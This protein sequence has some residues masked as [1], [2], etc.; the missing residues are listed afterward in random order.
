[1][2]TTRRGFL[3]SVAIVALTLSVLVAPATAPGAS[4]AEAGSAVSTP[5]KFAALS[6][7]EFDPG[8]IISDQLFYDGSAMSAAQIQS[9]L[10]GKIGSCLTTRCLNVAVLPVTGRAAS[11]SADTGALVCEAIAGG[12]MLASE[13]IYR[14]QVACGI[15]AKVILVTLQK[16]QGL[17]TSRAPSDWALRAAMGMGCP[18]TAPCSDAFSGL[19]TQIMAGTRQL[20]VYKVGRF[21]RQPGVQ[22]VQY[23]PNASCSGTTVNVRNY[24]T[25]ALYNY[26]PYQPN[27]ASLANLGGTGDS[28]S[29]YGNRNFWRY[30]STWFGSVD[31]AQFL[32]STVDTDY[33]I[34]RDASDELWA[35]PTTPGG[36]WGLRTSLGAGWGGVTDVIG[37]G[38]ID[39]NG[40]RDIIA[41]DT[42]GKTW[43]YPGGAVLEYPTRRQLAVD[44]PATSRL[45]YGGYVD[46][47]LDPD[48]LTIDAAG[49]LWMWPG[50]GLGGFGT[51][52]KVGSGFADYA[53]VAGVGD[54][55]GDRCAD[56]LAITSA[57]GLELR[58]GTCAG[59]FKPAIRI[60]VG[61]TGFTG[62]YTAG[63]FTGDGRV[64]LWAK[65]AGGTLRLFRGTGAGSISGTTISDAGWGT[66]QN[67]A[68]AGMRP[69][70]PPLVT[71]V[72]STDDMFAG[73]LITRDANNALWA[74]ASN[75]V[76]SWR[77]PRVS[78]GV[79]WAG[80][81]DVI[82]VGDLD[83]NGYRDVIARDNVGKSWFYPGDGR[84][85]YPTRRQITADWGSA[86]HL[87]YGGYFDA[88]DDPD[89]LTV[90]S[91]GKL[92]FWPGDGTGVF[93]AKVEV[94]DGFA[95]VVAIAG[96]G[97]FDGDRCGDLASLTTTGLL[98]LHSGDCAGG[99][100]AAR[101]I[102]SGLAGSKGVYAMGD[103]T[104]DRIADLWVMNA[105]GAIRLFRGTG[106][107]AV[108]ATSTFDHGWG[109]FQNI[110]G[111]GA[112][113]G[114]A[115]PAMTTGPEP[116]PTP[117]PTVTP[118]PTP[119]ATPTPTPTPT[120]PPTTVRQAGV[121]DVNS[122]GRRDILG[123]GAD[124][125]LRAY[126]GD[127]A[128]GIG[129]D[130]VIDATWGTSGVLHFPMGD[131]NGDG[132]SDI[133]MITTSGDFMLAKGDGSG[134]AKPVRLATQWGD[135]DVI[136]G[137]IDWDGDGKSDIVGR[138]RTGD[139][140]LYRGDGAGGWASLSGIRLATGWNGYRPIAVGDF[141]GV[142]G[143]DMLALQS[144]GDLWLYRG[145]GAGGW[146][147]LNGTR[148]G[149]GFTQ[150]SDVFSPGDFNGVP[151]NDLLVRAPDGRLYL[152]P[153]TGT[154]E[155]GTRVQI[156]SGWQTFR[157]IL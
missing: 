137:A 84:L 39:G 82:G 45:L 108:A 148:I 54:F 59:G 118:T 105:E 129:G 64:D 32:I 68:G 17:V 139:L 134:F 27:A 33:L 66:M 124:G 91:A 29:S 35:Y 106:G 104:A 69:A 14:T 131:W 99:I 100:K 3:A 76:G 7:S 143:D 1:M 28:C 89:M 43:F 86:R 18:D 127:G 103:F 93:G 102:G 24:A 154:G 34:T 145:N 147:S 88:G 40:Y 101:Q 73:Y 140:W 114:S 31:G 112:R 57:G 151:G 56:L 83:G 42:A 61:F 122:D 80:V 125:K 46:V 92:W 113:P 110:S 126:Y 49:D 10:D 72:S 81:K 9:F 109:G 51:A 52:V 50:D 111:S 97:D 150:Y 142:A 136:L 133:G 62:L 128:G 98:M 22:F 16:E 156:D 132:R 26:T 38:D 116:T 120:A 2:S 67:I 71:S 65:D 8:M 85:D 96:I 117:T 87:L 146:A 55:T 119:T 36:G 90:D 141:D 79:G 12:N 15:S 23:H 48:M 13:L 138:T 5:K 75:A 70:Y 53:L 4:A 153:G 44:W 144:N 41:R 123:V 74:Y 6:G 78:L 121:G 58:A 149:T 94:A 130:A 77:E 60:G 115:Y 37:V 63:D 95:D 21:G 155:I 19:A 152:I 30:Y 107:G 11:Y 135:F 20:K 25:A 157:A 47:G